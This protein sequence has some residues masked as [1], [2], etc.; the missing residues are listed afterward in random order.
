MLKIKII[1]ITVNVMITNNNTLL[2]FITTLVVNS[3]IFS[4]MGSHFQQ[5]KIKL[6]KIREHTDLI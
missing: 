4:V 2:P 6:H 1:R 5:T 3:Y